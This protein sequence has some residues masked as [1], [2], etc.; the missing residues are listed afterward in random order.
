MNRS[1]IFSNH[2]CTL[3]RQD[4]DGGDG[5]ALAGQADDVP[6]DRAVLWDA[7]GVPDAAGVEAC[8]RHYHYSCFYPSKKL[9]NFEKSAGTLEGEPITALLVRHLRQQ[10]TR[11][12][13]TYCGARP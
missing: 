6:A 1:G 4:G 3:K 2:G 8:R 9:A 10:P 5:G 11:E 12:I 13:T 7:L